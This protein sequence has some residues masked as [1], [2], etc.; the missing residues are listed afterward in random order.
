M[1]RWLAE[2]RVL[3]DRLEETQMEAI[4]AAAQICADA[5][6][7]GGLVHLFGA[8]HSRIPTEEMFP[9][10]GSYPGFHPMVELSMTFHTQIVGS[11]GQRQA[12]FIE[13]AAGLAE[14][15]LS[16][17]HFGTHDALI[18]FSVSGRSAV[19]IEMA[20]GARRRGLPVVAVTS[21]D[22]SLAAVSLHQTGT[23]LLDHADVV[24]DLGTPPG[25][26][27]VGLDGLDEKVGP[28][29]TFLYVAVANEIKVQTAARLVE[30]NAMPAVI[31]SASQVGEE[32]SR[33]LFDAAYADHATRLAAVIDPRRGAGR[34]GT[35]DEKG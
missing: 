23:R 24:I 18:V 25:D 33:D 10:Y 29:S 19:P 26:A 20:I 21:R 34:P 2:A 7:A 4:D 31:T 35:P 5:I 28:G 6:G 15:I 12:M 22:E 16:N 1:G 32:R 14:V 3:L 9:R 30:R 27:L 8:G 11:N 17:Y 13:R